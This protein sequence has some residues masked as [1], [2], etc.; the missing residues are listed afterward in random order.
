MTI[1][2]IQIQDEASYGDSPERLD[3]LSQFNFIYGSNGTGK[4]T[5]SRV[6][7]DQSKYPSCSL[8]WQ[9]GTELR[10]LV[11]NR[12][13]VEQN[14]GQSSDIKGVFTLGKH[15]KEVIDEIEAT[16]KEQSTLEIDIATLKKTLEGENGDSGKKKDLSDLETE[17]EDKCWALKQKHDDKLKE[18]FQGVRNSKENHKAKLLAEYEQQ[19]RSKDAAKP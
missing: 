16:K 14:F 7:A 4:T 12:D 1:T 19:G 6:I 17:F 2:A 18:A 10:T 9:G 13:F 8:T 5:V 15:S 3:N 11:Y